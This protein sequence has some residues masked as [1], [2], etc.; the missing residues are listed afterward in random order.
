VVRH[1]EIY[2]RRANY[3]LCKFKLHGNLSSTPL[4]PELLHLVQP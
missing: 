3:Q 2:G 1:Y 4:V